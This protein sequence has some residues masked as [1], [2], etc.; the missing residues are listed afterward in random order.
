MVPVGARGPAKRPTK[1]AI[2]HGERK[3]R[4]NANEPKP[5][6]GEVVPPEWLGAPAVEVWNE[7]AAD[8]KRK[9]VLTP[10]DVEAYGRYCDVVVRWRK[11]SAE[12]AEHGEV[13]EQTVFGKNGEPTGTR[14]AK[15]PWTM[16][17]READSQLQRYAA[18]FG[19]TPSDRANLSLGEGSQDEDDDLLTG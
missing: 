17:L 13:V 14:L 1:I 9:G 7:L 15:S 19:L 6:L 5:D 11:A 16:V 18:R 8:L 10:W 3:D 4:L 2:L 12:L